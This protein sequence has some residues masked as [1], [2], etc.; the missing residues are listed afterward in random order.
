MSQNERHSRRLN[1]ISRHISKESSSTEC[2]KNN[3]SAI[4][5][6]E[7]V[8]HASATGNPSSYSRVHGSVS[9]L[10]VQWV[11]IPSVAGK[12]LQEVIYRKSKGEGI[13]MV[14]VNMN[15]CLFFVCI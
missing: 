3:T 2:S 6:K 10:P 1:V 7:N 5:T 9:S 8:P 14:R 15:V 4:L 13:A 12:A 11:E